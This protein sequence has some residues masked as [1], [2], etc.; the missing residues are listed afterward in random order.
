MTDAIPLRDLRARAYRIPT[1]QPEGDGTLDW[2]ATTLVVTEI[3]AGGE[4]GLGYSYV[5]S[6][7][8]QVINHSLGSVLQG[9]D[10]MDISAA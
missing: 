6:G 3:D 9:R 8:A 4:V 1:D 7:A 5:D 2:S 10:A